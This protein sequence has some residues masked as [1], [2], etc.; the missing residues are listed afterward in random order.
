M[1]IHMVVAGGV[2]LKTQQMRVFLFT[3]IEVEVPTVSNQAV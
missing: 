1:E 2:A 3:V